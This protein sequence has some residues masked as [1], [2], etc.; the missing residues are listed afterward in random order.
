MDVH[1]S[2]EGTSIAEAERFAEG[3]LGTLLTD[4]DL[5][6]VDLGPSGITLIR[7]AD[8]I[9]KPDPDPV[10]VPE[11]TSPLLKLKISLRSRKAKA[12]KTI[13]YRAKVI[14]SGSA[15]AD[16]V[17]VCIKTPKKA[18]HAK[19][20]C[21]SFGAVAPTKAKVRTFKLR[22]NRGVSGKRYKLSFR[23]KTSARTKPKIS[24]SLRVK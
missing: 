16:G 17:A 23:T 8:E 6:N 13:K 24:A 10:P 3:T 19:K 4:V 1:F 5:D 2:T 11:A 9:P 20:A 12:G 14:N 7:S 15:E 18:V 22:I 21:Q